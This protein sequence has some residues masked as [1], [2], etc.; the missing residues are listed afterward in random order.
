M[1]C[2]VLSLQYQ[3]W[4]C[5]ITRSFS[6]LSLCQCRK[7]Y[8]SYSNWNTSCGLLT[9]E[10]SESRKHYSLDLRDRICYIC[11]TILSVP[12]V[13]NNKV[14]Y[15]TLFLSFGLFKVFYITT[16]FSV[17]RIIESSHCKP[18]CIGSFTSTGFHTAS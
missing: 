8:E 17:D 4:N 9:W 16:Q 14:L 18:H 15:I 2:V 12:A 5:K 1:R 10:I 6:V 11:D 7:P 13:I 3:R